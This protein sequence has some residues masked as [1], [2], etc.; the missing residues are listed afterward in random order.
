MY[1]I[2]LLPLLTKKIPSEPAF[3]SAARLQRKIGHLTMWWLQLMRSRGSGREQWNQHKAELRPQKMTPNYLIT[4]GRWDRRLIML[5][6][7]AEPYVTIVQSDTRTSSSQKGLKEWKILCMPERNHLSSVN[8]GQDVLHLK[9]IITLVSVTGQSSAS[10]VLTTHK[11]WPTSKFQVV[12]QSDQVWIPL[13]YSL[14]SLVPN[15]QW[16]HWTSHLVCVLYLFIYHWDTWSV[17]R[18][19]EKYYCKLHKL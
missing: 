13:L 11:D 8:Q 7:Q 12:F 15:S 18:Q 19:L 9:V 2:L 10:R 16:A 3:L 17:F 14:D 4:S 5:L 1:G 6:L